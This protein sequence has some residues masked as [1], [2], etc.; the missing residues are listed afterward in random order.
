MSPPSTTARRSQFGP[1]PV[2][3][4]GLVHSAVCWSIDVQRPLVAITAPG[5]ATRIVWSSTR[6]TSSRLTSPGAA[7]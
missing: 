4:G 3:E 2:P 6:V 7:T 5:S 1:P